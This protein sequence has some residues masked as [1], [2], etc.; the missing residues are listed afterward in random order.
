MLE[1]KA[2]AYGLK[3]YLAMQMVV[4]KTGK[5]RHDDTKSTAQVTWSV[6]SNVGSLGERRNWLHMRVP[7]KNT[8]WVIENYHRNIQGITRT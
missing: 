2:A 4:A 6:S 1:P 3:M 7:W 5:Y 8:S